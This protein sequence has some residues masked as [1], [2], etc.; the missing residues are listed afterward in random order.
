MPTWIA[1]IHVRKDASGD[2]HV[3]LIPALLAGMT[4]LN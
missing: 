2:I 3:S 4:R 1:G